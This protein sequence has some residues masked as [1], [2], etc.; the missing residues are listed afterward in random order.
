[1]DE[2][3]TRLKCECQTHPSCGW[4]GTPTLMEFRN[5]PRLGAYCPSCTHWIKWVPRNS[6]WNYALVTQNG[7]GA[8]KARNVPI[9]TSDYTLQSAKEL[10]IEAAA[11][12]WNIAEEHGWHTTSRSTLERAMLVVTELAELSEAARESRLQSPSDHIPDFTCAEEEWADVLI[13]VFDHCVDDGVS[14]P[15]LINAFFA[16]MEYNRT[17]PY[18]HGNKTT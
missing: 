4:E 11:E 2:T 3:L 14:H 10:M 6:V 8:T 15:A 13:R 18:R 12:C 7:N 17:R 5:P 1:M 9:T 16:K